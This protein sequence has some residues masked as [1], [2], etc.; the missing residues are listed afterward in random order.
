MDA[1]TVED[2]I[3]AGNEYLLIRS[4]SNRGRVR[5]S[6]NQKEEE[7]VE[8]EVGAICTTETVL[9]AM[10]QTM[11]QMAAQMASQMELMQAHQPG[12]VQKRPDNRP[13]VCYGC[14][15]EG[16]MRRHCPNQGRRP[17]PPAPAQGNGPRPQQ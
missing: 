17:G 2:T 10:L 15:K 3:R 11:Q 9:A 14:G 13:G 6:I 7:E 1:Q 16:H 4:G 5:P 8:S 12:P